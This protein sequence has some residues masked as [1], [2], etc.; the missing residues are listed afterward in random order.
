VELLYLGLRPKDRLGV[1]GK[2]SLRGRSRVLHNQVRG[3]AGDGLAWNTWAKHNG[4]VAVPRPA[5]SQE[6]RH[7][8][9][10]HSG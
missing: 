3:H 10:R 8:R 4:L 7:G 6:S 9:D 5:G 2:L 1:P